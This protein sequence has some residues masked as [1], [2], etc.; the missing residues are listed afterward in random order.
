MKVTDNAVK[1]LY[2]TVLAALAAPINDAA[3]ERAVKALEDLV[4]TAERRRHRAK[5]WKRKL[6]KVT[7]EIKEHMTHCERK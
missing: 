2:Y 1:S 4:D 6:K 7:G 5:E 3:T